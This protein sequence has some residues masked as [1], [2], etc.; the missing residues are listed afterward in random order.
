M[1]SLSPVRK[2]GCYDSMIQLGI[3]PESQYFDAKIE[4]QLLFCNDNGS[5]F[6]AQIQ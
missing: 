2:I 4:I 3:Q 5:A 6:L 1:F